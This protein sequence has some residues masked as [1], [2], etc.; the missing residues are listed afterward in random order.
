MQ[1]TVKHFPQPALQDRKA[2]IQIDVAILSTKEEPGMAVTVVT[3][4]NVR[5]QMAMVVVVP[6]TSVHRYGLTE[7]K[8]FIYE[9]GRTQASLKCDDESSVKSSFTVNS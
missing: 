6:S 1:A 5:P 2:V 7:L 8:R 4:I 3:S 9:T